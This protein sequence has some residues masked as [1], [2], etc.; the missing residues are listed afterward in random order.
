MA[1]I[2]PAVGP[3]L[4]RATPERPVRL[5]LTCEGPTGVVV[6]QLPAVGMTAVDTLE[7]LGIVLAEAHDA[8]LGALA[9]LTGLES[10]EVEGTEHAL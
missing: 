10:V 5:L 7:D 6:E 3:A 2:D 4:A 1:D 9:R 8:D